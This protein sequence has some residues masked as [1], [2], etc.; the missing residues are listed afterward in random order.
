MAVSNLEHDLLTELQSKLEAVAV[1]ERYLQDC[2]E[3]GDGACRRLIEEIR[4]DDERHADRLQTQLG[5]LLGV[6]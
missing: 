2:D 3:A 6:V 4:R 5:R 1:Y